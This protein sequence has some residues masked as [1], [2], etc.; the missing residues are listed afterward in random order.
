M[1]PIAQHLALTQALYREA[2]LLDQERYA[3]WLALLADD[4][5]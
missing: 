5:R 2:R 4:V 1:L 3:D